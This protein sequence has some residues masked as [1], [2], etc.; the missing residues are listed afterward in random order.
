MSA[1]EQKSSHRSVYCAPVALGT[2]GFLCCQGTLLDPAQLAIYREPQSS[3][4]HLQPVQQ[5]GARLAF[6]LAGFLKVPAG[7]FLQ[8]VQVFLDCSPALKFMAVCTVVRRIVSCEVCLYQL[9]SLCLCSPL[10]FLSSSGSS[11]QVSLFS[12]SYAYNLFTNYLR[13]V[14]I[15]LRCH[16]DIGTQKEIFQPV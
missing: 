13:A 4:A 5:P 10:F 15:V 1:E 3:L 14:C 12:Q 16:P 6:V 11:I 7:S 8:V 2:A 9:F